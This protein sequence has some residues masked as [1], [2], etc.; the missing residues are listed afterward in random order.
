[1]ASG[2]NPH[3]MPRGG[4]F[5]PPA[6]Q[7]DSRPLRINPGAQPSNR[8]D[9]RYMNY[10]ETPRPGERPVTPLWEQVPDYERGSSGGG[11]MSGGIGGVGGG[12]NVRHTTRSV[13]APETVRSQLTALLAEDGD[14]IQQARRGASEAAAARGMLSSGMAAGAAQA[15]AIQA[16]LP[17]AQ[18]DASWYGQTASD[19]MDAYN[20]AAIE[21]ANNATARAT[22]RMSVNGQLRQAESRNALERE[23][24]AFDRNFR[25]EQN[26][27]DSEEL[28][29][30]D[31]RRA[32]IDENTDFRRGFI[33]AQGDYRREGIDARGDYRQFGE[34]ERDRNWQS[35]ER[36]R[37]RAYDWQSQRA[38]F[39]ESVIRDA[40]DTIRTNPEYFRDPEGAAGAI[41]FFTSEID[42]IFNMNFG[43]SP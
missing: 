1:M 7:G 17:I 27:W 11:G 33:D 29:R 40:F 14:Y 35:G 39:R 30:Q 4:G 25:R 5:L 20:R 8:Q 31:Y 43:G 37:E 3:V 32:G 42:R 15:A 6:S 18:Q 9:G 22:T 10:G 24:N 23:Q 36:G 38:G 2:Y 13:Q 26:I 41:D 34:N 19:N 16:G 21:Q 12:G 28:D